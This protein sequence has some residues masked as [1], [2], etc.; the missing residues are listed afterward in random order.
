MA[1]VSKGVCLGRLLVADTTLAC[2]LEKSLWGQLVFQEIEIINNKFQALD[3]RAFQPFGATLTTLNLG[4]TSLL[5]TF[6]VSTDA[7]AV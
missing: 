3:N 6:S 5:F 1:W 4:K 7:Q 2:K